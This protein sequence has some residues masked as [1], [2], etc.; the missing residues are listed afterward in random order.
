MIK[1][2]KFV[3][4]KKYFL[5]YSK[6]LLFTIISLFIATTFGLVF[7]VRIYG[8]NPGALFG[9]FLVFQ[10]AYLVLMGIEFLMVK[11]LP[12]TAELKFQGLKWTVKYFFDGLLRILYFFTSYIVAIYFLHKLTNA[13]NPSSA[14]LILTSLIFTLVLTTLTRNLLLSDIK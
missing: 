8:D 6:Y 10:L 7:G 3:S 5:Q 1:G 4:Y 2:F 14:A 11:G 13:F 12:V 9:V